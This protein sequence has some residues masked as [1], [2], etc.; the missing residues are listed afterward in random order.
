VNPRN[1]EGPN[2][3]QIEY[4]NADP[5]QKW[6]RYQT[7]LD[8]V[9]T[10]FTARLMEL[11]RPAPGE[12]VLD[13]GCGCGDTTLETAR[14]VGR[15]GHV[16][17]VDVS[18]PML[19]L[20]RKRKFDGAR[21]EFILADA[22]A[23]R[24]GEVRYDL[25]LSRF[26]VMFFSDPVAA[27]KNIHANLKPGGRLAFACWQPMPTSPWFAI[28]VQAV[29]AQ[30][31]PQAPPD[32]HAPGPFAFADP[33]RVEAIL[34]DAGFSGIAVKPA[35]DPLMLAAPGPDC[36][37]DAASFGLDIGPA[38][39]LLADATDAQ[40]AAA[41]TALIEA[42]RPH[43]TAKGIALDGAIWLVEARA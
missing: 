20:A 18:E 24:L 10:P 4:W 19:A 9:F 17:G 15:A 5:G 38:S 27:F 6:V 31:P 12:R 7:R 30:L 28:A 29:R 3:D 43:V 37:E 26:G 32:P 8:N 1:G 16:T 36:L 23:A 35:V 42:L 34:R 22:A 13:I 33:A 39:R 14:R 2:A 40:R 11:A 25:A 41:R 21:P